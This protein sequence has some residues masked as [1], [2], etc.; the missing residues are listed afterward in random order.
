MIKALVF[1]IVLGVLMG[2]LV[3]FLVHWSL[4]KKKTDDD[5]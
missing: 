3:G 2:S 1:C 5:G 4:K